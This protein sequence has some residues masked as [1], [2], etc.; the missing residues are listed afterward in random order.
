MAPYPMHPGERKWRSIWE[1]YKTKVFDA[2]IILKDTNQSA[3]IIFMKSFRQSV[4]YILALALL[5][6]FAF[7]S[8]NE[9]VFLRDLRY[10]IQKDSSLIANAHQ[11]WMHYINSDIDAL[12]DLYL[13]NALKINGAEEVLEGPLTIVENY[14]SQALH[15]DSISMRKKFVA[16]LDS[17]V[18][19]EIGHFWDID[20]TYAY[21]LLW[22]KDGGTLKR[23]L[24]F[25]TPI[26]YAEKSPD[27]ITA[28]REQWMRLCNANDA[29]ALVNEMYTEN[30]LYYN[31][32][33]I[34]IGREA[35]TTEYRYMNNAE[36]ELTLNPSIVEMVSET[37][38]FEIGRCSGSYP[39]NYVL[40]WQKG[41]DGKWR[42]LLD[43]NI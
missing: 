3:N 17:T 6:F 10:N 13:K 9:S 20:Q 12:G 37:L 18:I 4:K 24:E 1:V 40:I 29:A 7:S 38:A 15:I 8:G 21:L 23:E 30:A 34:V 32:R 27:E 22:R 36:Y 39:G 19:Y 33:P 25:V 11:K 42:I 31:H 26:D 14:R 43:S 28:S 41:S 16:V 2:F 5:S 35:I